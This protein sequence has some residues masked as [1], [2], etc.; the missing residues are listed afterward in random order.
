MTAPTATKPVIRISVSG[1]TAADGPLSVRLDDVP[2]FELAVLNLRPESMAGGL[3]DV[4]SPC[5]SGCKAAY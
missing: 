2:T 5:G 1:S 4:A 3:D